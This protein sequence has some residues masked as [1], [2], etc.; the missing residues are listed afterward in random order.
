MVFGQHCAL[1]MQFY[2]LFK[3]DYNMMGFFFKFVKMGAVIKRYRI[4][5][6]F[7]RHIADIVWFSNNY[8]YLTNQKPLC[9]LTYKCIYWHFMNEIQ[10]NSNP[11]TRFFKYIKTTLYLINSTVYKFIYSCYMFTKEINTPCEKAVILWKPDSLI[12]NYDENFKTPQ[13]LHV[14]IPMHCTYTNVIL[15]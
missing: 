7:F 12:H 5:L 3:C 14:H 2:V 10:S 11:K 6:V 8:T 9:N 1:H 15:C 4:W 13:R